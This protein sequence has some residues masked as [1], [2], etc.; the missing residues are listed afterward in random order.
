MIR[1]TAKRFRISSLGPPGE[2]KIVVTFVT[3]PFIWWSSIYLA[4]RHTV[5]QNL[6]RNFTRKSS[7]KA[8]QRISFQKHELVLQYPTR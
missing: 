2:I 3:K 7:M 1:W 6:H 8:H 5:N 4:A